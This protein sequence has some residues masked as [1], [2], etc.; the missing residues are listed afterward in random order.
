M[1]NKKIFLVQD[2]VNLTSQFCEKFTYNFSAKTIRSIGVEVS[3]L[4]VGLMYLGASS[5]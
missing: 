5:S 1:E 3:D 4:P 2:N